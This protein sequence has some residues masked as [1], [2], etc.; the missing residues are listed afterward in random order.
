MPHYIYA[1]GQQS[2]GYTVVV[3]AETK[4]KALT[5]FRSRVDPKA[6]WDLSLDHVRL[7]GD[8]AL[9]FGPQ[10]K[11]CPGLPRRHEGDNHSVIRLQRP[12]R[13]V[14]GDL[15][16][17]KTPAWHIVTREESIRIDY[18]PCCGAKMPEIEPNPVSNQPQPIQVFDD[19]VGDCCG[20]CYEGYG[21]RCNPWTWAWRIKG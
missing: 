16:F 7:V 9:R 1:D 15:V 17:D 20:T 14:D 19:E 2:F 4:Q 8:P 10:P 3:E 13:L 6:A 18:C 21:C 11:C 12:Y 5:L